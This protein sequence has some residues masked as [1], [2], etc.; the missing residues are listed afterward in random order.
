MNCGLLIAPFLAGAI[1]ERVGY[2]PV[3]AVILGVLALEFVL[4]ILVIE[5]KTAAAWLER[6]SSDESA[7]SEESASVKPH[8]SGQAKG[9][10]GS[11]NNVTTV[12]SDEGDRERPDPDECSP[13]LPRQPNK[14]WFATNF[15][16]TTVLLSSPRL[17]AAV[18]GG[19]IHTLIIVSFDTILPLFV[20]RTFGWKSTAGGLIFLTLTVPSL[21][22]SF[23]GILSDRCGARLV[24]LCGFAILIPSLAFLGLCNDDSMRSKVL[25]GALL[26]LIG[27]FPAPEKFPSQYQVTDGQKN[28]R[29]WSQH[30][31]HSPRHRRIPPGRNTRGQQSASVPRDGSLCAGI[32]ALQCRAGTGLGGRAGLVGDFVCQNKLGADWRH[33]SAVVCLGK[34]TCLALHRGCQESQ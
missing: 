15:P 30:D 1:Y 17:N 19:F 8:E 27:R 16:M 10:V 31:T 34:H 7:S 32:F 22:S 24:A 9:S 33:F 21:L 28:C 5:K 4:L 12:A 29:V 26:A 2:Y 14:S 25:L 3:F 6:P 11:T 23:I 13:L 20:N 18:Y